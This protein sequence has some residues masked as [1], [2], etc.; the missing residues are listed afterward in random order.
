MCIW[1][2]KI[3]GQGQRNKQITLYI[4]I[5]TVMTKK[6]EKKKEG[7]GSRWMREKEREEKRSKAC[8]NIHPT[9]IYGDCQE[10]WCVRERCKQTPLIIWMS[11]VCSVMCVMQNR[12]KF[13]L[14]LIISTL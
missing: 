10:G 7:G 8:R 12:K 3:G 1:L 9:M 6:Q 11:V 14:C 2:F 5:L 13:S 4:H